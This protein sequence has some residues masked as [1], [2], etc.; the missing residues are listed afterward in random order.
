M[1]SSSRKD[2]FL[3]E[4]GKTIDNCLIILFGVIITPAFSADFFFS[5]ATA[6]SSVLVC[7]YRGVFSIAPLANESSRQTETGK[8][9][10]YITCLSSA[11][12]FF[13]AAR[14]RYREEERFSE[15]F[16][17]RIV[18]LV[19]VMLG[20]STA[21]LLAV[22]TAVE[23]TGSFLFSLISIATLGFIL[24]G[25][26]RLWMS[27]R[28]Q[29][30]EHLPEGLSFEDLWINSYDYAVKWADSVEPSIASTREVRISLYQKITF[31]SGFSNLLLKIA[32]AN[33]VINIARQHHLNIV[34]QNMFICGFFL[35]LV[36]TRKIWSE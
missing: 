13:E 8:F 10:R 33:R 36:H 15:R 25:W 16:H 6:T 20:A 14:T 24:R 26:I 29:N 19:T 11:E 17:P 23:N 1:S 18:R 7:F 27:I 2:V 5:V 35:A 12:T 31:L 4:T 30:Y 21:L 9:S 3:D 34:T 28:A 32:D 22:S